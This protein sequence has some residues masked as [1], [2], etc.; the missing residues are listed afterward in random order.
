MNILENDI[1]RLRALEPGDA[2][3]LYIWEN[4]TDVWY[5]GET[6]VPFSYHTLQQYIAGAPQ[7]IFEA[8]QLRF[9]I[10]RAHV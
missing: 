10:G 1:V 6:L 2:E 5:A 7:D 4:D 8:K 3:L 9:K